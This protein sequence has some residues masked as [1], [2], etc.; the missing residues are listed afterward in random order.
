MS[1]FV[2]VLLKAE[3]LNILI[4]GY[5]RIG[6]RKAEKYYDTGAKVC[7]IDPNPDQGADFVMTFDTYLKAYDKHFSE[8]HLVY[9]CTSNTEVNEQAMASCQ[10]LAKLYNRT[11]A[12][13]LGQFSDMAFLEGEDYLIATSGKAASPHMAKFLRSSIKEWLSGL[14]FEAAYK[15]WRNRK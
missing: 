1:N 10:A 8:Q 7:S 5:G 9:I 2:P 11:D 15:E 12:G 14:S 3:Q 13:Q 4:I 6:R